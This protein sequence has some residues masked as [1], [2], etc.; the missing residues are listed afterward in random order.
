MLVV[1]ASTPPTTLQ[2]QDKEAGSWPGRHTAVVNA[3]ASV[4]Y[5]LVSCVPDY[6]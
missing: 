6:M 1:L 5:L 4:W 2:Q 3:N